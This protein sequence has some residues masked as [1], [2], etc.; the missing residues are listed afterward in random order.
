[1]FSLVVLT[2]A[3]SV[4][5]LVV[6]LLRTPFRRVAGA[7]AA[8]WL[9]LMVPS[10]ALAALLPAPSDSWVLATIALPARLMALAGASAPARYAVIGLLVWAAGASL[11]LV[12]AVHRQRSFERSLGSLTS[13]PDGTYQSASVAEPMLVGAWRPRVVLPAD[14][15]TRYTRDE[16]A[17]VLAHERAH[18][19]RGD[20]LANALAS[21]CLCL[22]WFNPLMYWAVGQFRFDQELACDASVL[23]A[24]GTARRRYA[25][26]LLKA[27]L[28]ADSVRYVPAGCS[29]QS[30]HRLKQRIAVLKRPLPSYVRRA[31]GVLLALTCISSGS[32]VA[33]ATRAIAAMVPAWTCSKIPPILL[34]SAPAKNE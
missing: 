11:M 13:L 34:G 26:A 27:Q 24:T 12:F 4:S 32:Y 17:L 22:S 31:S 1:M 5:V 14:F 8:Y 19:R 9:W 3:A 29:W 6:G 10:S 18:L 25:D 2:V 23:A 28:A 33:W 20:A 7:Q 21:G 30:S 15:A 16:R